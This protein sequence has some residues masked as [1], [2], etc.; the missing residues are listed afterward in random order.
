MSV[1]RERPGTWYT[2]TSTGERDEQQQQQLGGEEGSICTISVRSGYILVLILRF[3]RSDDD[4]DDVD[5]APLVQVCTA[6]ALEKGEVAGVA[7]PILVHQT[8][9]NRKEVR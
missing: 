5:A 9:A 4:D 3:S 6:R 7:A 8:L 2:R 1:I